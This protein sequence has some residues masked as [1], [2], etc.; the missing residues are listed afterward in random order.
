MMLNLIRRC[1]LFLLAQSAALCL[2]AAEY[3][4]P[5]LVLILADDLGLGD[6]GVYGSDFVDTPN[7]DALARSVCVFR[8][9]MLPIR[10]AVLRAL[11]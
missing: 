5:N 4:Q 1:S 10:F 8:R 6:V 7:I 2:S 11:V 3:G 9:R